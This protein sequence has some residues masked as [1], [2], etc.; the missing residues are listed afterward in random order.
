MMPQGLSTLLAAAARL[1][2]RLAVQDL[3]AQVLAKTRLL[4]E[5]MEL[6]FGLEWEAAEAD[7]TAILK[8]SPDEKAALFIRERCVAFRDSPPPADWDGVYHAQK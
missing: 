2:P 6:Y 5:A 1:Y 3:G 4:M 8:Q 7:F